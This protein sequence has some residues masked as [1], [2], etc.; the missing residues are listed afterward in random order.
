MRR[1]RYVVWFAPLALALAAACG[2]AEIARQGTGGA[3]GTPDPRDPYEF[4]VPPRSCAYD[5][6]PDGCAEQTTPYAC[7]NLLPWGE[8]P[9]EDVCQTWD[10]TF[11]TPPAGQCAATEPAGDAIKYAGPDPDDPAVLVL[12]GGRRLTPAGA[13]HDFT[14]PRSMTSAG[15]L[16]AGTDLVLTVDT[17]YGDH[18]VRV[19]DPAVIGQ[20]DPVVSKVLFPAPEA[21]NEGIAFSPPDR[22][23]VATA[24]GRVQALALDTATGQLTRDDARSVSLPPSGD[25]DFYASGVAVSADGTRLFVSG[26]D[27]RRLFVVDVTD[28]GASYGAVLGSVDLGAAET[29]GVHVDPSDP[30]SQRVYVTMWAGAAVEEVDVSDPAAPSVSR[31]FAVGRN[32]Q[33][34]AFLDARW[35]VVSNDL[36]DTLSVVDRISGAVTSMP[37]DAGRDL[38][39]LEPSSLFYDAPRA[40]LYA[41]QAGLNAVAAYDVDAA[42]DPPSILP[43]G[44]L[45]AQWWPS[46]V[47]AL[48]DGSVVV[49]SLIG[50]G[51]GPRS[52]D[53]EYELLHG[54]IQRVPSPSAA[55]LVAG[56]AVVASSTR[57]A[58]RA[59][60]PAIECPPGADDFPIPATNTGAPSPAI[61]HVIVIVRENKTFDSLF[62]DFPGVR[63]DPAGTLLPASQMDGIWTN[64]RDLARTFAMSDNFYTSAVISTQG[65]LWTTH[66][67][68]DDY[69]ERE[70]PVTGYGRSLRSDADSGG[71]T[72]VGRPEEGS[73]F[74]WLG[75]NAVPYD[76]LGEIVGVP[77]TLP[78]GYNPI[79]GHYPG[80][81]VQSIGYPDVEKA[82]YVAGRARVLCDLRNVVYMTLPNDHTRGVSPDVPSPETMFATND[83]ATGMLVDAISH[84]PL[85]PRSLVI[86]LE[87]DPA[88][89]GESVDYHRT[90]LVMASPWLRRG[91]TSHANIDISSVHKLIA[92]IFAIPYPNALV[93][94]AALPLDM[95][96]ST[97][98]MTPFEYTPRSLP[99]GCGVSATS[100]ERRLT[101]SWD[102]D[103]VDEQP[104]LGA[105]LDR[106]LSGA[107]LA[108]LPPDLA[109]EIAAREARRAAARAGRP[110]A[111]APGARSAADPDD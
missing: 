107:Q 96:T 94:D 20:G 6:P 15:A 100:A 99:L 109:A 78:E 104:G 108:E 3:G 95:F 43:A 47:V 23:F 52:P 64:V 38:K 105:Q 81:L 50:R 33:G 68:T 45:P 18:I 90:I 84:G 35:M 27:D 110:P 74:E 65:H 89:G 85:W 10:G 30:G 87:D 49:T 22:V 60:Y 39:G 28:G 111:G 63:G 25:G 62:G 101:D 80:G 51:T 97:P 61:D 92:H 2:D 13:D 86:V 11:A 71:V 98:D 4:A 103:E 53:Q 66:G 55:D 24:Q 12:P 37:V 79:D 77:D 67:R 5:C 83:E 44:R 26:V 75:K 93:E 29:F 7:P 57:V 88:Q 41:T 16:V 36:G 56:E 40:R 106:W 58:A 54:G 34:V 48:A 72:E 76:L 91:Y 69:N 8:I 17:G 73:M 46:G 32:P 70:W 9:H 59:G 31:T 82:C 19:V 1:V 14:D 21:L 102:L 42:A